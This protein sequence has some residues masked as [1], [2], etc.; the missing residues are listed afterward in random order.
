[1]ENL[2]GLLSMMRMYKVPNAR[3]SEFCAVTKGVDLM[4]AF[5]RRFGH[6]VRMKNDRIA[7]RVYSK[8]VYW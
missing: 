2:I 6:V 5:L 8:E 7:K 4:N 3:I 1:M